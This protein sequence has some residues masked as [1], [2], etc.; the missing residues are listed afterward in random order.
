MTSTN[1]VDRLG[2]YL[3]VLRVISLLFYTCN[4]TGLVSA[5]EQNG[6]TFSPARTETR[7]TY[8]R[9]YSMYC[10]QIPDAKVLK[11]R[12]YAYWKVLRLDDI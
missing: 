11:H 10:P 1:C 3:S 4:R 9:H 8:V 6:W 2:V 12:P 7:R 5:T